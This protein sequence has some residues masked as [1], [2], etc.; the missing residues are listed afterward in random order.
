MFLHADAVTQNR[1]AGVRTGRIHCDN[2]HGAIVFA[3]V[4]GQLIDQRALPR[5]WRPG[6]PQHARFA[7]MGKQRLQEFGPS[8]R[9]ILD[10]RD[11]ASK[12]AHVARAERGGG[13]I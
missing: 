10:G 4:A 13:R 11:G 9:S 6:E 1:P 8:R 3:I 2:T 5:P 12:G 7:G